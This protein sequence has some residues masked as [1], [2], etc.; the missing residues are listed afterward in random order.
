MPE[1]ETL[2]LSQV[3]VTRPRTILAAVLGFLALVLV[4]LSFISMSPDLRVFFDDTN[5]DKIALDS[6]EDQ[7][8]REDS[9]ILALVPN[10]GQVFTPETLRALAD[11]VDRAWY[12]PYVRRVDALTTFQDSRAEGDAVIVADLIPP[13]LALDTATLQALQQ[14]ALARP[15]IV[16]S[17]LDPQASATQVRVLFSLPGI[18]LRNEAPEAYLAMRA[19]E[20]DIEAAHPGVD[21]LVSGTV[22]MNASFTLAARQD[23]KTLL[24][25]MVIVT[26]AVLGLSL[27]SGRAAAIALAT[28]L[29]SALA[30]ISALCWAGVALN[31]AT[32]MSPL[33]VLTLSI[34]GVTHVLSAIGR[35]RGYG[36]DLPLT[37]R[38]D[39]VRAALEHVAPAVTMS[40]ITTILGFLALNFSIS[41]PFRQ[42]GNAVASGLLVSLVLMLVFVPALC[43]VWPPRLQPARASSAALE[44]MTGFVLSRRV[45]VL[46]LSAL[47]VAGASSGIAKLVFEDDFVAYFDDS[48]AFRRDTDAIEDRLTGLRTLEYPFQ[49]GRPD[50]A[51]DPAFLAQ[52]AAFVSW[53]QGHHKVVAVQSATDTLQ[54]L[55]MNMNGDDPSAY[56]LPEDAQS[57]AQYMLLYEMSLGY[58]MDLADRVSL[59]KSALRVTV[60]LRNVT[61]ADTRAFEAEAAQWIGANAPLLRA[62][63]TGIAHV[64]TLIAFRD[65]KAMVLGT[66]AAL[67]LVSAAMVFT[68]RSARLGMIS[69]VPNLLPAAMAFGLWGMLSGQV[70][71]AIS[72]VS[73]MTFGIVVDDTIHMLLAFNR[74]YRS[75]VE[76]DR[77]IRGAIAR[78]GR[79]MVVTSVGLIA[80]F[81]VM[82]LSGFALNSDMAR[83]TGVTVAIALAADLFLLPV[84]LSLALP[85]FHRRAELQENPEMEPV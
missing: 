33:I 79:P 47:L 27:R 71:L 48:F 31:T 44:R 18:D 11:T 20:E 36:R 58:G 73:A 67:V 76:R 13:D 65:A 63:P 38:Q 69:L 53:A 66:F 42:L 25:L 26:V 19:L 15:E 34:A 1:R 70:T 84:I 28:A 43:V 68:V 51:Y 8:V 49:S 30:G 62:Q 78:V 64:F 50:G 35:E 12:L 77:A 45:P 32:V 16:G 52:T 3:V 37:T 14:R 10:S 55:S 22:A 74:L 83:L 23:L 24:P 57:A 61:T 81:G 56:R 7:F 9:G 82:S 21:V 54:Q 41:P 72:V 6:F 59:D 39:R 60:V 2:C 40:L 46:V 5:P 29:V 80:G 75:G 4:G 17:L 85:R